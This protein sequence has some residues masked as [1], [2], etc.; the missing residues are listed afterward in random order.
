MNSTID[1][2]TPSMARLEL[3][4]TI[5]TLAF[6]ALVAAALLVVIGLWASPVLAQR[7]GIFNKSGN[8]ETG[9]VTCSQ[10]HG[11]SGSETQVVMNV[12]DTAE[13]GTTCLLYTSPSP[14]D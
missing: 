13:A 2:P 3:R 10:C 7:N 4:A 6:V 9:G 14:R 12:F 1:E 5:T 11:F 8:P